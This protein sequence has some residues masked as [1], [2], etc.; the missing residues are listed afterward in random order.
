MKIS[1]KAMV[2]ITGLLAVLGTV[3]VTGSG[4]SLWALILVG[5]LVDSVRD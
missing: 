2:G 3:I 1:N 4:I 5:W